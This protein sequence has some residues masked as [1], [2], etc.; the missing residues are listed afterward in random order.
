[1]P[2]RPWK[3]RRASWKRACWFSVA[4][5]TNS[6]L[7]GL[8]QYPFLI[9]TGLK[10]RTLTWCDDLPFRRLVS[11]PCASSQVSLTFTSFWKNL[12]TFNF[13]GLFIYLTFIFYISAENQWNVSLLI[14]R[15]PQIHSS[16]PHLI[17][18]PVSKF[19]PYCLSASFFFFHCDQLGLTSITQE[20]LGVELSTGARLTHQ[21]LWQWRKWLFWL[22]VT[23]LGGIPQAPPSWWLKI[24]GP[25]LCR[26]F[27]GNSALS[28]FM[29][30][31][32]LP[33]T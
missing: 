29:R 6:K 8:E 32:T 9:P 14:L 4:E 26:H 10:F 12:V 3:R 15:S 30:V 28:E 27:V 18:L 33:C 22:P 20:Y 31:V 19:L 7:S 11:H 23:R 2:G 1:M 21:W 17:L 13:S 25:I 16:L 5:V 24:L